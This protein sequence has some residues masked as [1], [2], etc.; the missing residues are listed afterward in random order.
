[1][2][3]YDALAKTLPRAPRE[4]HSEQVAQAMDLITTRSPV[5]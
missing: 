1:M 2:G 4:P 3:K 5:A